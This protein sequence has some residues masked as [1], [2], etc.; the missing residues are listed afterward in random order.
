MASA[1]NIELNFCTKFEWGYVEEFPIP[2]SLLSLDKERSGNV[3]YFFNDVVLFSKRKEIEEGSDTSDACKGYILYWCYLVPA[4][5]IMA[6]SCEDPNLEVVVEFFDKRNPVN[7]FTANLDQRQALIALFKEVLCGE[8]EGALSDPDTCEL[9]PE[10]CYFMHHN[11]VVMLDQRDGA[12]LVNTHINTAPALQHEQALR[13]LGGKPK[14]M[15]K[16]HR[17]PVRRLKK[18]GSVILQATHA[19]HSAHDAS[20]PTQ[21]TAV[22]PTAAVVMSTSPSSMSPRPSKA[23]PAVPAPRTFDSLTAESHAAG[24]RPPSSSPR[25]TLAAVGQ[26]SAATAPHQQEEPVAPPPA[27][28]EPELDMDKFLP[29]LKMLENTIRKLVNEIDGSRNARIQMHQDILNQI[30]AVYS[31]KHKK[32]GK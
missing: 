13:D 7:L 25:S 23:L 21:A 30:A 9:P 32:R 1:T 24:F 10:L 17:R 12:V 2:G 11:E 5:E 6:V 19:A 29:R 16:H 4:R 8:V 18:G 22:T 14:P 3:I 28:A 20:P 27:D 15:D 26:A 31:T